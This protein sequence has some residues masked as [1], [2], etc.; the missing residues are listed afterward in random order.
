M[1]KAALRAKKRAA[2][3]ALR[4]I[5]IKGKLLATKKRVETFI[6]DITLRG[7]EC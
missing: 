1:N 2:L 7:G 5:G 6:F 3:K 4:T